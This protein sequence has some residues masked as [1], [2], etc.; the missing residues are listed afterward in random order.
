MNI[1][2]L[3]RENIA[4]HLQKYRQHQERQKV[5]CENRK[6]HENLNKDASKELSPSAD[7]PAADCDP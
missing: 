3:T 2:G 5:V 7:S 6:N 1:D 4:S